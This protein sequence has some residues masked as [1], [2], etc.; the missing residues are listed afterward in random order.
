MSAENLDQVE[1][2]GSDASNGKRALLNLRQDFLIPIGWLLGRS[3]FPFTA[4][5]IIVGTVWWSPWV[6]LILACVWLAIV[7]TWVG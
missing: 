5:V 2:S 6:S 7:M 3:L 1:P 4:V